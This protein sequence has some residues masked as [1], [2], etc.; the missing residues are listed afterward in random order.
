MPPRELTSRAGIRLAVR[1]GL[2][3]AA[4]L[5][6][7]GVLEIVL[8]VRPTL[9]GQGFASGALSRYTVRAGGI[10]YRD[11]NLR[12]NFMIPNYET[13]MYANGYVV[14]QRLRLASPD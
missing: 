9:L 13:T 1:L 5:V 4:I 12:M 6:V 8:R 2:I 10:Y 3:V 11:R 14:R 7:L